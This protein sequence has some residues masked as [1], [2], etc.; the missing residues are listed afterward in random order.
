MCSEMSRDIEREA[1]AVRKRA[2]T[3][4]VCVQCETGLPWYRSG[5]RC[6]ECFQIVCKQ[7]RVPPRVKRDFRCTLCEK[8]R[9][10]ATLS[11]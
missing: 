4:G 10:V 3:P 2:A 6:P 8:K 7:C 1:E 11:M 9:L 5:A